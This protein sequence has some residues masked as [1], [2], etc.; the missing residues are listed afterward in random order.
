MTTE[1]KLRRLAYK[2]TFYRVAP[3]WRGLSEAE[4]Q[5][6][7]EEF[8][9]VVEEAAAH[10]QVRSYS[11]VGMKAD[12]DLLLWCT[13]HSLEAHQQLEALLNR[14]RLGPYLERPYS[15]LALTRRSP[16]TD[17]APH[18]PQEGDSRFTVKP[19]EAPYLIVYP[20]T[21]TRAWYALSLEERQAMMNVHFEV[22]HK[23][24]NVRINTSYSFGLDD[25]EFVVAFETDDPSS[26]L[27]LVM[28]LRE[29]K[30]SAYTLRDTPIFTCI[31]RPLRECLDAIG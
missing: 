18:P 24:P 29:T 19:G 12:V 11:L 17:D 3:L 27:D 10:M 2:Y 28:E 4:K 21:K 5:A 8:A 26:F 6:G 20:F 15:Y 7:K 22:G 31:A 1:R 14:T 23:Y 30:A 13:G 9:A 25:Q 16:Y